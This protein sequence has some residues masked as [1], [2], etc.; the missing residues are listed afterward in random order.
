MMGIIFLIC[1]A[2]RAF[3]GPTALPTSIYFIELEYKNGVLRLIGVE[4]LKGFPHLPKKR[5]VLYSANLYTADHQRVYRDYFG[6]PQIVFPPP[7]EK[8]G[9]PVVRKKI[10]FSVSLPYHPK[11]EYVTISKEEREVLRMDVS[12][13]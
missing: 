9:R 5:G 1:P 13:F 7:S 6:I 4:K 12:S 8:K 2:W 3:T 11:A 10:E